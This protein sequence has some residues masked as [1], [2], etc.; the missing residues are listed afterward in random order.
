MKKL[1]IIYEDKNII[2]VSKEA[3]LLT[4]ATD[5]ERNRTLY[6]EVKEYVKKQYPKNKI[7]IIHRLDKDTSGLIV[8]AKNE[9]TKLNWQNNWDKVERKYYAIVEGIVTNK[10]GRIDIKLYETKGLDVVVNERLGKRCIT[11]YKV[12]KSNSKYSLLDI[13]IKT[14]RRNQIRASMDYIGHPI[15]GDKKYNSK[16]N[17]L[18]KLGLYAYYIKYKDKEFISNIPKEFDMLFK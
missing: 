11:D 1:K 14:G 18:K 8:F 7:F 2:V 3:G 4:V 12:I 16:S 5:K 17:P 15:I 9:E 13:S 6:N 10:E